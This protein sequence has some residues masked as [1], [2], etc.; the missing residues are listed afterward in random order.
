MFEFIRKHTK[1]MQFL[2]FML[3]FPSFVLFGLDGYSRFREKGDPVAS[4]DGQTIGQADWDSAHK[5]EVERVRASMPSLDPKLLDSPEAKYATLERLVRDRVVEAAAAKLKLTA[6]DQRVAKDLQENPNIVSLRR[7]D[8]SLDMERYRQLVGAQGMSPEM[9]EA[10]V[11]TD[12]STRQVIGGITGTGLNAGAV[13]DMALNAY[14]ERREVQVARFNTSD[15][16]GKINPTE[17]QLEQYYKDNPGLFQAPEQANLEY[18]VLDMEAIRKT[19]TPNA[20]DVKSYFEQ[21][22]A[23]LNGNEERRASH[24]LIAS[25]KTAPPADRQKAK[26][27]ADDLLSQLKKSPDSFAE[28]AKKNSQDPGSAPNGGDLDFFPRGAMVKPF[29]EAAFAMKKGD[30][31][32]VVESEFGYH[33]IRLMDIKVAKQRSF[34]EMRPE[35]EADLK[36]QQATKKFAEVA[37]A[38]TNSVYEQSDNLKGV[39]ERLKLEL[40]TATNVQRKPAASVTGV[41]ANPKFLNAVFMPETIEKK[42]NT[43]AVEIASNQLAS[44]RVTLYTPARTLPFAEVKERVR[45]RVL[46]VQG[47]ELA[48]KDGAE[49][50]ALWKATPETASL[51]EVL[52]VSRDQMQKLPAAAID[53]ALRVDAAKL[54]TLVGVDLGNQGYMVVKINKLLERDPSKAASAQQ[55]RQQYT[56]WWTNAEGLAY[57][58]SLKERFKVEI[59]VAKPVAK[60]DDALTQ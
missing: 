38:F 8:G 25:P 29:E 1:I 50:L 28:L 41:L 17:A 21:N 51:S 14:F 55:D 7:P 35:I 27:K 45:E 42:R 20:E 44:G 9:F 11:R 22:A 19:I 4:V 5:N 39:A 56:Q 10:R 36:K 52:A 26:T 40:K 47:A 49:K 18:L 13:A 23:R 31:S 60:K 58:Q 32:A 46:A 43:E 53:A 54:P 59:K 16:A 12:L 57:Y 37:E 3:I 15:F 6:S 30:I 34:E 24:I 48:R 2:L 33:I